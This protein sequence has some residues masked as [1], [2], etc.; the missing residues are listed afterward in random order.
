MQF[1]NSASLSESLGWLYYEFLGESL[2][3]K[4]IA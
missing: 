2:N 1:V 4:E 3:D